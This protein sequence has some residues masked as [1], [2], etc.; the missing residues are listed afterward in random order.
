MKIP[1]RTGRD[2]L[3]IQLEPG[4]GR[5]L[6]R[7]SQPATAKLPQ[8]Q[9]VQ[10]LGFASDGQSGGVTNAVPIESSGDDQVDP[11]GKTGHKFLDK[12]EAFEGVI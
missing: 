1:E 2:T 7:F 5:D 8:P 12:R 6:P 4:I 11:L 3:T 10:L 9:L